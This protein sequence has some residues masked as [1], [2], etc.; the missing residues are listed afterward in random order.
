M[1]VRA[2]SFV[3]RFTFGMPFTI[4]LGLAL[5]GF[6]V[7]IGSLLSDLVAEQYDTTFPVV[8]MQGTLIS[9]SDGEA[10]IAMSGRKNRDCTYVG[11]RA[12]SLGRDGNLSDAYITRVDLPA[13]GATRPTG[14]FIVGTWRVWPLPD[15]RGVTVYSTHLCGS[16]IVLTKMADVA[17][18]QSTG[19]K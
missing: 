16:R 5:G 14:S 9:S 2:F 17:L 1:I 11:I 6:L 7:P 13:G 8:D 10:V 3:K 12:Y 19:E 4:A 15:S 18:P